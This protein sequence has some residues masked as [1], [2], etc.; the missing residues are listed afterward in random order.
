MESSCKA[1][2]ITVPLKRFWQS[3]AY[4]LILLLGVPAVADDSAMHTGWM[5]FVKGSRDKD[6]GTEVVDV[7]EGEVEGSR[8]VTLA[9][10]KKSVY[11]PAA[12][13]EVL[14]IGKAPEKSEPLDLDISF[15]WISDYDE[16]NYGL[17]IRLSEDTDW[18]IRLYLNSSPGFVR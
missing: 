5:E 3:V 4:T 14:V 17:I 7:A 9:I 8:I 18:P 12:I 10:P 2:G 16:D 11:D 15:E 13:E 1:G 6:S